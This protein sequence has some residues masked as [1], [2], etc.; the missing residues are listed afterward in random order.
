MEHHVGAVHFIVRADEAAG[1]ELVGGARSLTKEPL[2]SDDWSTP[3]RR[4]RLHRNRLFRGVLDID[5]EVVLHV[6]THT[7]EFDDSVD[8]QHA[9]PIRKGA[10]S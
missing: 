7:K 4:I 5:L 9:E 3:E 6:L 1:F 2:E 8:A 10:A